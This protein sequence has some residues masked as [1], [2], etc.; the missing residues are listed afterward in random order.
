[1]KKILLSLLILATSVI[2]IVAVRAN[3]RLDKQLEA[4]IEALAAVES[5]APT[6]TG[7]KEVEQG[8]AICRCK[9]NKV[10]YDLQGCK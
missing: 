4:N 3:H 8:I 1:M 10:C 6:C 5:N 9:N 7:P 2:L